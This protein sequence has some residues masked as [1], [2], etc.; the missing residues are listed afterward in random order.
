MSSPTPLLDTIKGPEDLRRLP[1]ESLRQVADEL[2]AETISAVA[3]TGGHL[4]AGLGVVEL[5]VAL[6]YVFDTP[7]DQRLVG[8][9]QVR[10]GFQARFDGIPDIVY[11]D[12][13]HFTAGDRGVSEWTI[14]GTLTTGEPIEVRGCDLFEFR[15]GKV[16]RKDSYWKIIDQ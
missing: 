15:D 1:E 7:R 11:A 8:K 9:E 16:S 3:V 2:R 14:R 4:G 6:H 5:T 13:R 12:D 10:G